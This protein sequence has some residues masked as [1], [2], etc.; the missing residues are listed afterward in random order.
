MRDPAFVIAGLALLFFGGD[1][2]VRGA[3]SLAKR[4]DVPPLVIAITVVAF[5]TSLPE[6]IVSLR[7]ALDGAP[8]IAIGNVV[9]SNI[10]NIL[11]VLGLPAILAPI[12]I[13]GV[14]AQRN[15]LYMVLGTLVFL[16]FAW[17]G[18]IVLWEGIVLILLL[19]AFLFVSYWQARRDE[20]AQSTYQEEVEQF[21]TDS[22]SPMQLAGF[23]VGGLAALF[24]GAQLLVEGA[25]EIALRLGVSEAVIG[26]TLV[27]FGTS[28]PE[29]VTSVV[30]IAR[31]HG[32]V[33]IGN[34][35]GSNLF[36]IF[37]VLGVTAIV[38][39]LPVAEQVLSFDI[40]IMLGAA[41]L[42]I[43][44]A[45]SWISMSRPVGFLLFVAYAVYIWAQFGVDLPGAGTV[46]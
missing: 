23:I 17:N 44:F 43:P 30:A 12:V 37:G 28:L 16:G 9:G 22:H 5:G 35:L 41:V 39:D 29:L 38:I 19:S 21:G 40:W 46:G 18:T 1:F 2:L 6:M 11:L 45:L 3:V 33:A 15:T 32:D 36:N 20:A 4:I 13:E 24:F 34:I 10:A 25:V 7:A 8:A 42:L 26:L 27:A 31:K 14:P